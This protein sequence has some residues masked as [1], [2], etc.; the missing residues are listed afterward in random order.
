MGVIISKDF[1]IQRSAKMYH[2]VSVIYI[3][4]KVTF[5]STSDR[6]VQLDAVNI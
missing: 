6:T 2:Q 5:K 1:Y 4:I 3:S